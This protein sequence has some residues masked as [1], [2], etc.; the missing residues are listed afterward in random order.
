MKKI[1]LCLFVISAFYSLNAVAQKAKASESAATWSAWQPA[2]YPY[3]KLLSYRLKC[4]N[5]SKITGDTEWYL[6]VKN[7][8]HTEYK[9]D[10]G[11]FPI[12]NIRLKKKVSGSLL[13]G[14]QFHTMYTLT[15]SRSSFDL[16]KVVFVL[17]DKKTGDIVAGDVNN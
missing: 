4:G 15:V 13:P 3:A 6:E 16:L 7:E 5:Y 11:I 1:L 2:A 10:A 9:L 8:T 17:Y 12:G 14:G